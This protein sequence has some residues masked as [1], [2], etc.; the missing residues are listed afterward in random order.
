MRDAFF[1]CVLALL[2]AC[3]PAPYA[4]RGVLQEHDIDARSFR[5]IGC[6]D[7]AFAVRPPSDPSDAALLVARFGNRCLRPT[8]F[9]LGSAVITGYDAGGNAHLLRLVDPRDEIRLFHI[10]AG[11]RGVEKVRITG[12]DVPLQSICLDVTRVVQSAPSAPPICFRAKGTFGWEIP[13]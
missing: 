13:S 1:T 8:A 9:D 12:V 7:L 4:A 6:L 5:A 10:D 3:G 2:G 11:T